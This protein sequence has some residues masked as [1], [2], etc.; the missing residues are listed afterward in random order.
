MTSHPDFTR[1]YI[2][3]ADPRLGACVVF[4]TDDFF[5]PKE[6][7]ISRGE[8]VFIAGKYD[9]HGKW[10]DG[11]ESRRKRTAGHDHCIV[12]LGR[13]GQIK[14]FEIDTRHFTGNFPPAA[15]V[16][17]CHSESEIPADGTIW[18]EILP[19]EELS[20]DRQ[21]FFQ[22]ENDQIW[23]HVRLNIYPDGGVARLRVYG[24]IAVDWQTMKG[25]QID[26]AAMEWGGRAIGCNDAHFG[27]PANIISPTEMANMG[28]GWETRRR[29]SPGHDHAVFALATAGVID[30]AVIETTFFK[31]NYPDR[32]SLQAKK[33]SEA[34]VTGLDDDSLMAQ[35]SSWQIL[36]PEQKL[37]ADKTHEFS[38]ELQD[39]GPV[40]HVRLNIFPDGG[41]ARMRL[42]GKVGG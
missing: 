3:L 16:G 37:S 4:A 42:F 30:H 39:I 41:I 11:W 40:S 32:F 9:D 13:P 22:V 31:G 20:G 6:R 33:I 8:P 5:A 38:H 17:V 36:L 15:S 29:R 27:L 19:T 1:K 23:S 2:N 28:D 12:K 34:D 10:M 7:L 18:T 21:H 14:G 26:L 35:S 24:V 25:Q